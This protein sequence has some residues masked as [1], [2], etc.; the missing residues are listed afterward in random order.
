MIMTQCSTYEACSHS[1]NDTEKGADE[2]ILFFFRGY[3]GVC[4]VATQ[5]SLSKSKRCWDTRA[6]T[7]PTWEC[8]GYCRLRKYSIKDRCSQSEKSDEKTAKRAVAIFYNGN[9]SGRF[10]A[11][12]SKKKSPAASVV[13]LKEDDRKAQA[14]I[15]TIVRSSSSFDWMSGDSD[16]K[17]IFCDIKNRLFAVS[18]VLDQL[19]ALSRERERPRYHLPATS[20]I[21]VICTA[22]GTNKSPL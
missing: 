12:I 4:K 1:C 10:P 18:D 22:L 20:L 13:N 15:K 2:P 17:R 6:Y 14:K 16:I 21:V 19:A 8:V 11:K 5:K 3:A 7:K 9:N